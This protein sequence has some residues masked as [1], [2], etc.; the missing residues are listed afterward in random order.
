MASIDGVEIECAQN[1]GAAFRLSDTSNIDFSCV[2]NGAAV[3]L[4][5]GSGAIL[6]ECAP[7]SDTPEELHARAYA[8]AQQ[9]LDIAGVRKARFYSTPS[10]DI[11]HILWWGAG[12]AVTLRITDCI[13]VTLTHDVEWVVTRA[14]GTEERSVDAPHPMWHESYRYLRYAQ[15]T[16][17]LY[18]A[19]R[20]GY[21]ALESLLSQYYPRQQGEGDK[22]WNKRALVALEA[23]GL[24]LAQF[25]SH[26][27]SNSVEDFVTE[28][29]VALRCA[30]DHAKVGEPHFLPATLDDRMLVQSALYQLCRFLHSAIGQLTGAVP[31]GGT[32]T[33]AGIQMFNDVLEHLTLVV[34]SD[35]TPETAEDTEVSP[36]GLP[37]TELPTTYLRV[38]DPEGYDY[39]WRGSV[40]AAD[41][42]EPVIRTTAGRVESVLYSHG[43]VMPV[44]TTGVD[45]FEYQQVQYWSRNGGIRRHYAL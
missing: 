18:N 11:N 28:Q 34:S 1:E 32:T 10:A 7:G 29:Y 27:G 12:G 38:V 21:L 26:P 16:D 42:A 41:L 25:V 4:V 19:Y 45:T 43:T 36:L 37:V 3:R 44:D 17:D 22:A 35:P 23:G 24:N 33:F 39:G 30:Q 20:T 6:V 13:P 15:A 14:D 31:A 40:P 5:N 2:V 9:A 8:A